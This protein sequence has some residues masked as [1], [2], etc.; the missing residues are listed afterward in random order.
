M[1]RG[2]AV[3]E[4]RFVVDV[5]ERVPDD[6]VSEVAGR[7]AE[8]LRM[9]A[10]RA[11]TLLEGRVGALTRPVL[12][13]KADV[14]AR[15]FAEA[16]VAVEVRPAREEDHLPPETAGSG[17]EA[18][19]A[20]AGGE[21]E[22]GP[23]EQGPDEETG[24]VPVDGTASEV[25][26]DQAEPGAADVVPDPGHERPPPATMPATIPDN[27]PDTMPDTMFL[28]STRWVP[29]PHDDLGFEDVP[30]PQ[31]VVVRLDEGRGGRGEPPPAP[32]RERGPGLRGY[33]LI[34]L[35]V[36]L[37]LLLLLQGLNAGRQ[38]AAAIGTME[39]A[40]VAYRAGDFERARRT[41]L[42][43]ADGG[44]P[45]AQYMLGYM[46]ETGLGQPWSNHEAAGWYQRA[47]AQGEPEAQLRLGDLYLRGMGVARDPIEG[48]RLF[49]AAARGGDAQGAY[50]YGL[51]LFRGVGVSQDFDAALRWFREAARGGV[52]E[53]EPFVTFAERERAGA[54]VPDA[55]AAA[56]D[57]AGAAGGDG[58]PPA[59][60][61]SGAP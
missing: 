4:K 10:S 45:R 13:E 61:P 11:R 48:A 8:R 5:C 39:Q 35:V 14:I 26:P 44:N 40:M 7:V 12:W 37:A 17:G 20:D 57:A 51:A 31:A 32:P 15:T 24:G 38:P 19:E 54:R 6:R 41:W 47:A 36:S 34:G 60:A 58:G 3:S 33:L 52:A 25:G 28:S 16:G 46:A 9:D 23:D 27:M 29:S 21:A 1:P 30:E 43:L 2:N 53:A 49:E 22:Q 42:P 55:P 18:P 50:R 56:E 59:K